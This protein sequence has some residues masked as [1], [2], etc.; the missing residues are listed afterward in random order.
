MSPSYPFLQ[1]SHIPWI[2]DVA[3]ESSESELGV[4]LGHMARQNPQAKSMIE[5]AKCAM[6][7][8]TQ[9][10]VQ[11]DNEVLVLFTAQAHHY[12]T[13]KFYTETKPATGKVVPTWNYSAVQAYSKASIFFDNSVT[14]TEYLSRQIHDLP[15]HAETSIMGYD[16]VKKQVPWKVYDAPDRYIALLQKNIIGIQVD[17]TSLGGKFNM[18]REMLENDREGVIASF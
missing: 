16:V 15:Q 18:S 5:S 7:D 6:P 2:V 8:G 9:G 3:D 1:T 17:I 10:G 14:S 4:L 11:L 13:P 12:V